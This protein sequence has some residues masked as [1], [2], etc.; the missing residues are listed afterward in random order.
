MNN[1][2]LASAYLAA[3]KSKEEAQAR[4]IELK[5]Q[6]F[7]AYTEGAKFLNCEEGSLYLEERTEQMIEP[8]AFIKFLKKEKLLHLLP[9][10]IEIKP[11]EVKRL[12]HNGA[13]PKS[14]S[15]YFMPKYSYI[16]ISKR[17]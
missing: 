7:G 9:L 15:R 13:I 10:V 17:T 5:E 14:A 12:I 11:R 1:E 16:N 3:L 6:I 4:I 8:N 2:E